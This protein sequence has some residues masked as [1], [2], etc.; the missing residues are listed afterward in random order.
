MLVLGVDPGL[1]ATGLALVEADGETIEPLAL[2]VL[3]T[4]A[5]K[6][7]ERSKSADN[8][9]CAGDIAEGLDAAISF[10]LLGPFVANRKAAAM[11][12]EAM[13]YPPG[14]KSPARTS[15]V[16]GALATLSRLRGVPIEQ[17]SPQRVKR[18]L[19]G[20]A[21]ASKDEVREALERRFGRRRLEVLLAGVRRSLR[22]HAHD[23]LAAAVALSIPPPV[24]ARRRAARVAP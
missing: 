11:R 14:A 21:S 17:A 16:W 9:K 1:R 18:A 19:T 2:C 3:T 15:L 12:V 4:R 7:G 10:G 6:G 22:E 5:C 24:K 8:A 13:S 20:S 23:A